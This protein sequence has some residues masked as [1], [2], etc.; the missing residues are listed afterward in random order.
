MDFR[1]YDIDSKSLMT[2]LDDRGYVRCWVGHDTHP[3][4]NKGYVL[5]HRLCM[6]AHLGRYLTTDEI[7]HHINE[8]K[9]A[10]WIQ[11][12]FLCSGEEH[13]QIHNR[14]RKNSLAKRGRISRG[15]LRAQR[16]KNQITERNGKGNGE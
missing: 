6:E 11:N 13:V 2:M 15:V 9:V 14:Y 4:T 7:V 1:T 5:A 3:H 10:N 16:R 8:V 12:L